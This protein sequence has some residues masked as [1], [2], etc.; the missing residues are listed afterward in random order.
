VPPPRQRPR[1]A[2]AAELTGSQP[3]FDGIRA[4]LYREHGASERYPRPSRKLGQEITGR[5]FAPIGNL[6]PPTTRTTLTKITMTHRR[7]QRR[8]NPS[9]VGILNA[10]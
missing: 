1:T 4:C 10:V 9:N 3:P 8:R 5:A 2:R 7:R 6:P